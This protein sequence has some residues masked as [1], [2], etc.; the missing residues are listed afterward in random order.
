MPGGVRGGSGNRDRIS[1]RIVIP[2]F[3]RRILSFDDAFDAAVGI[4]LFYQ[5]G[6]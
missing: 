2:R 6:N 4:N 3:S 1:I 5:D